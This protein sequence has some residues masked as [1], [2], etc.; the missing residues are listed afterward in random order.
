MAQLDNDLRPA[1]AGTTSTVPQAAV[2]LD[3]DAPMIPGPAAAGTTVDDSPANPATPEAATQETQNIIDAQLLSPE[4]PAEAVAPAASLPM[5]V[6]VVASVDVAVA[7]SPMATHLALPSPVVVVAPDVAA[8]AKRTK[9][10]YVDAPLGWSPEKEAKYQEAIANIN[11]ALM[12]GSAVAD[13]CMIPD[14]PPPMPADMCMIPDTTPPAVPTEAAA[15]PAGSPT[16]GVPA[17]TA[18]AL[19]HGPAAADTCANS[20]TPPPVPA[21]VCMITDTTPPAAPTEAAAVQA[22][23]PTAGAPASTAAALMHGPAAADTCANSDTPD[24]DARHGA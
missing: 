9:V 5:A 6:T 10:E 3:N 16:A 7:A 2:V 21:D 18:V 8:S 15:V 4:Q 13:T 19:M 20:G 1:E 17:S 11:M 22:G 14:T 12:H 23:S 24:A